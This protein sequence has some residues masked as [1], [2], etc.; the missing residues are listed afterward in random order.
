MARTLPSTRNDGLSDGAPL[1]VVVAPPP[2]NGVASTS[3]QSSSRISASLV[4]PYHCPPDQ[5][6][7]PALIAF[8]VDHPDPDGEPTALM[9]GFAA[10]GVGGVGSTLTVAPSCKTTVSGSPSCQVPDTAHDPS[11]FCLAS[12]IV[13]RS[14]SLPNFA[15]SNMVIPG[16]RSPVDTSRYTALPDAANVSL[17]ISSPSSNQR[18]ASVSPYT[19][20][21]K[22]M[23]RSTPPSSFLVTAVT[24]PTT[25][26][27][28]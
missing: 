9:V 25:V 15:Q 24:V 14:S 8:G 3:Y 10:V 26:V 21:S 4:A 12:V 11:L 28:E 6:A 7:V 23:S 19:G 22:V 18:D 17:S 27:S 1:R 13:N 16:R 20:V 2:N 5:N